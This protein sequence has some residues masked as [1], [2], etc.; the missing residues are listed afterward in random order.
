[1]LTEKQL[2]EARKLLESSQ[3]PLFFFDNDTDGLT[4]FLLMRRYLGRGKGVVIKSFPD[5]NEAYTRKINELNPDY[6]FV[7]DK[8]IISEK[9]IDFLEQQSIPLIW[10]DHH[11]LQQEIKGLMHYFNPLNNEKPTNEPTSYWC[12][13]ITH[14]KEDMW[15]ALLGCI[16]DWFLPEFISEFHEKYPELLEK[17]D[18]AA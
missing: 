4:S 11:P 15:L 7:L 1:M 2:L 18:T 8:P 16:G 9:F 13:K 17:Q 3:N 10:I 5:L 6:V 14:R 12:Y